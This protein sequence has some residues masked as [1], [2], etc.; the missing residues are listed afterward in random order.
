MGEGGLTLS[1]GDH[2]AITSDPDESSKNIYR[3]V[4]GENH[5]NKEMGW[6]PFSHTTL[7]Y[8]RCRASRVLT[9]KAVFAGSRVK[10][11]QAFM[12]NNLEN[13]IE[14]K[15]GMCGLVDEVD[16]DG[17]ANITFEGVLRKQWVLKKNFHC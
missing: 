16:A 6:F 2:V 12:S 4:Y 17:D 9:R 13:K 15:V 1:A 5:S 8:A 3:W 11:V 7:V 14:L 10:V